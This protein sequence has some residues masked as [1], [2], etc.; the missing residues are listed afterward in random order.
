MTIPAWMLL[1]F[2]A[3]TLILL[4]FT[5]GIYRWYCILLCDADIAGFRAGAVAGSDWYARG[6]RAHANCVE[7][8]PVFAVIVIAL[9]LSKVS[10][11]LV[12]E[13]AIAIMI[14]RILQ[15]LTHV[16]FVQ[17]TH[18]VTFRFG[19]FFV[20]LLGFFVLITTIVRAHV[21]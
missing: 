11:P 5:V 15:S 16:L 19:F 13:V 8:L 18:V 14:A 17:T 2:A 20:Q 3:W 21:S 1:A 7:N 12:D 9:N 6:T 10:G 4:T